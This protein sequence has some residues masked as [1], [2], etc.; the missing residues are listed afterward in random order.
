MNFC[1]LSRDEIIAKACSDSPGGMSFFQIEK[2]LIETEPPVGRYFQACR[3]IKSRNQSLS[4]LLK[5]LD[6]CNESEAEEIKSNI[7]SINKEIECFVKLAKKW[8]PVTNGRSYEEI[9]EEYW[10]QRLSYQLCL[11]ILIGDGIGDLIQ[12]VLKLKEDSYAR[13][14][15]EA[16]FSRD[17]SVSQMAL[18]YVSKNNEIG[19]NDGG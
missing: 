8:Y 7:E 11:R 10:D 2:F 13:K 17:S 19:M 4:G 15:T 16:I 18:S 6:N 3:E 14:I 5:K 1:D 9:Q 12:P